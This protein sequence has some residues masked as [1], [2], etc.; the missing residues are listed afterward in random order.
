MC[1]L[2][3]LS[4]TYKSNRSTQLLRQ[5]SLV[6]FLCCNCVLAFLVFN[7]TIGICQSVSSENS[8]LKSAT[9]TT[10]NSRENIDQTAPVPSDPAPQKPLIK[11]I[12]NGKVDEPDPNE[13][14][15]QSITSPATRLTEGGVAQSEPGLLEQLGRVKVRRDQSGD[16]LVEYQ[17]QKKSGAALLADAR[18]EKPEVS[19][20]TPK[21]VSIFDQQIEVPE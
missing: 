14:L 20:K 11:F 19:G 5:H 10:P 13:K 18:Q 9:E 15:K 1:L 3:A 7:P 17:F 21:Q 8:S 4:F 2:T 16:T 6:S 12:P